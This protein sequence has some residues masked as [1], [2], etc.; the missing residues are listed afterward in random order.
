MLLFLYMHKEVNIK[1][2]VHDEGIKKTRQGP[3]NNIA[4]YRTLQ[5]SAQVGLQTVV[6][7]HN[8]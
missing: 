5:L 1:T 6:V 4:N 7:S 3:K 2:R 8:Q